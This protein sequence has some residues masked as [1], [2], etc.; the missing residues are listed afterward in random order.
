MYAKNR[1]SEIS[2]DCETASAPNLLQPCDYLGQLT[3]LAALGKKNI[4]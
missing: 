3:T 1:C 2:T 4:V